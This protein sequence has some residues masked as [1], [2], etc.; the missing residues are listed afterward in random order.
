MGLIVPLFQ[1]DPSLIDRPGERAL[2]RGQEFGR[3]QRW[4]ETSMVQPA[5]IAAGMSYAVIRR[6]QQ[7]V[8]IGRHRMIRSH[9]R[10]PK[11]TP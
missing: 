4:G 8:R 9:D 11:R 2:L 1:F 6:R 5:L 7:A 10:S 3:N